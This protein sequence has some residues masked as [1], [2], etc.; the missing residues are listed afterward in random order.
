VD[1]RE[2]GKRRRE[3]WRSQLSG[4]A[5]SVECL[6]AATIGGEGESREVVYHTVA[7]NE[8]VLYSGVVMVTG[9]VQWWSVEYV[10]LVDVGS[11]LRGLRQG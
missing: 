5:S 11:I 1:E 7:G 3:R 4:G 8:Y 6:G 9:I 2:R 10:Q